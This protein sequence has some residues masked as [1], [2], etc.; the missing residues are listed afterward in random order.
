LLIEVYHAPIDGKPGIGD[1]VLPLERT[2]QRGNLE[3]F[4]YLLEHGADPNLGRPM[5]AAVNSKHPDSLAIIDLMIKHG[6]NIN[7]KFDMFGNSSNMR[8]A[9][10]FISSANPLYSELVKRGA[11]HVKDLK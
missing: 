6:L 11:V 9:L 8:T 7:N 10:D 1:P 3:F 4:R 5:V 2:F